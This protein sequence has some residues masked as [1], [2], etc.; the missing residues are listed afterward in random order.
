MKKERDLYSTATPVIGWRPHLQIVDEFTKEANRKFD[1]RKIHF[2]IF[3]TISA[4]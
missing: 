3:T 2:F 1:S 4:A